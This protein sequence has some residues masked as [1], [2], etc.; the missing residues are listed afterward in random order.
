[1]DILFLIIGLIVLVL[2]G[3]FLVKGAVGFSSA[4]KI[5][6]LIIGMTVVAFGTSAP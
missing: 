2:G 4:M 3:E 6:P 1:M 5:S